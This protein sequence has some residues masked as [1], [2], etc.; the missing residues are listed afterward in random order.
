MN[1]AREAFI[2]KESFEKL[3]RTYHHQI[4]PSNNVKYLTGDKL[5]YKRN[6]FREWK[7]PGTAIGQEGQQVL[8]KHGSVYIRVHPCRLMLER[9]SVVQSEHFSVGEH[10]RNSLQS[11]L[12]EPEPSLEP[13]TFKMNLNILKKK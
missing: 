6:Q 13:V 1:K 3:R 4:R 5:Y 2:Q 11:I 10:C 7:G 8:V 9:E 12:E